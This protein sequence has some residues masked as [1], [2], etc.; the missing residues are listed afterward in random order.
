MATARVTRAFAA[1]ADRYSSGHRGVDLS[2]VPGLA[3]SA[4]ASATVRF[5][6]TVVDRPLITLD[7]GDGVLSSYEPAASELVPGE[8]VVRGQ[9]IARV[10]TG[11]HCG[12]SCLHIGVRVDGAYVS[13][14]LY[15]DR[16]PPSRL[17]PLEGGR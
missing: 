2:A 6:G 5:V 10:A 12:S 14:L 16:V 1:P 13:P 11:G 17:L 8:T 9:P 4:P 3:V 7:H 15:F